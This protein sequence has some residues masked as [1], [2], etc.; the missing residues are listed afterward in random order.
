MN[1]KSELPSASSNNAEPTADLLDDRLLQLLQTL[2]GP[3]AARSHVLDPHALKPRAETQLHAHNPWVHG[4][5]V[6]SSQVA[7]VKP[8]DCINSNPR[9]IPHWLCTK[10]QIQQPQSSCSAAQRPAK[11]RRRNVLLGG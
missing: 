1:A 2:E 10:A 4:S 8:V 9:R 3:G 6:Q 7:S 5:R 11:R